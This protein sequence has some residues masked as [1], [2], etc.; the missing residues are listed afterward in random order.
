MLKIELSNNTFDVEIE[1][2]IFTDDADDIKNHHVI[3]YMINNYKGNRIVTET[4]IDDCK[5]C[6]DTIL[7]NGAYNRLFK[8]DDLK[9]YYVIVALAEEIQNRVK[10]A[11]TTQKQKELLEKREK[12]I[13]NIAN[14]SKEITNINKQMQYAKNAYGMKQYVNSNGRRSSNNNRSR[15][16]KNRRFN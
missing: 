13:Q 8:K 15:K 12:E 10:E 6:I 2:I 14:L 5:M 9:P 11:A 1:G 4:F 7:G 3:D 16:Q